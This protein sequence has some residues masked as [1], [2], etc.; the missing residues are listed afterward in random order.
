MTR[1]LQGQ[2]A[3]VT[4]AARGLGRGYALRLATLGADVVVADVD[5]SSAREFGEVLTAEGVP[6]EIR[7][8][9][10]RGL[11]VQADLR[12]REGARAV[13]ERT[14]AEFGRIDILVN[15]AGG[16]FTPMERST[17]S[18]MPDEDTDAMLD[19][20][21]RSALFCSQEVVPAM[22]AR[23]SGV[24]VNV[25]TLAALDPS[26]AMGRLAPYAVAKGAVLTLTRYL[27]AELG[28][29]G[30][31]VNCIAPGSMLTE[32]IRKQAA[33]RGMQN[34]KELKRIP[35]RR[36]GEVDDCAN[37]LEFLVTPLSGYVTGQCISVCGGQV[38][39]PS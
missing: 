38:L 14:L 30:I 18:R 11:G 10:C 37:V 21:Y 22:R 19:V 32:R 3:I 31:R 26:R 1:P 15:N 29:D 20:N 34:E 28:P 23:G 5:L 16:A 35:L 8:L 6:E 13:V 9:G 33:E 4:G 7:A 36:F 12:R 24:I 17:A 27:A 2:V 25:A 39:T